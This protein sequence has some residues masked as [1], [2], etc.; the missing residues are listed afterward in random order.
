M[1]LG[2][3]LVHVAVGQVRVD[4]RGGDTGVAQQFLHVPEG[5]PVLQQMGGKTVSLS[6]IHI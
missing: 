6:L 3:F 1:A 4:L 2:I 5:G